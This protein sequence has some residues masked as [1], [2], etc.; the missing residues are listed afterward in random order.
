MT[1]GG[2]LLA[3][4]MPRALPLLAL[5]LSLLLPTPADA[6]PKTKEERATRIAA[7]AHELREAGR[8]AP[9]G[10]KT[11]RALKL[12]P[13]NVDA[14]AN[15]GLLMLSGAQLLQD[16]PELAAM[17]IELSVE[18]MAKVLELDPDSEWAPLARQVVS[19]LGRAPLLREPS[20]VCSDEAEAWLARAEEGFVVRDWDKAEEGY[21]ASLELCPGRPQTWLYLG[22]VYFGRGQF[23]EAIAMYDESLARAPCFWSAHRFKGDALSRVGQA[24]EALLSFVLAVSCN[25][26]YAMGWDFL[27]R[28]VE[29]GDGVILLPSQVPLPTGGAQPLDEIVVRTDLSELASATALGYS[30]ALHVE[31]DFTPLQRRVQA[32]ETAL[33]ILQEAQSQGHQ[34]LPEERLFW[35]VAAKARDTGQLESFVLVLLLDEE[36]VPDL[37]AR[38]E[39]GLRDIAGFV[40][41]CM[42]DPGT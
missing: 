24:D 29:A 37:L 14:W 42:I 19:T 1:G 12:D 4:P 36:I 33:A 7:K 21:R 6:A 32:L 40:I 38:Q 23:Q 41:N 16:E 18:A 27:G 11:E 15:K 25:P 20:V 30:L 9:S 5:L 13:D 10:R 17:A 34:L 3:W 22:D 31:G 2:R 35:D 8:L 28:V 26:D 39:T